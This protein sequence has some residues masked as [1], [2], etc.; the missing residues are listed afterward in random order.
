MAKILVTCAPEKR[1]R[2]EWF[3]RLLQQ[4]LTEKIAFDV[5]IIYCP[6]GNGPSSRNGIT[7]IIPV[8]P[9]GPAEIARVFDRV[10]HGGWIE[11]RDRDFILDIDLV[12]FA[13]W[14]LSREEEYI[15][16]NDSSA[17]DNHGRFKLEKTIA[18]QEGLWHCLLYTS[19]SPRDLS[20]SRMPSSA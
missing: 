3:A 8:R 6:E 4:R 12:R 20:T 2:A 16:R 7:L 17:W 10:K 15:Q 11:R 19:P 9:E 5:R 18:Y 14:I 1:A 13:I